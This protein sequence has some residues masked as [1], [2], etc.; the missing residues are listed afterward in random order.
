LNAKSSL[1]FTLHWLSKEEALIVR[2]EKEDI[3]TAS[4]PKALERFPGAALP[5]RKP[6]TAFDRALTSPTTNVLSNSA[7]TRPCL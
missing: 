6:E 4:C 2:D 7:Y 1:Y 3:G 5:D